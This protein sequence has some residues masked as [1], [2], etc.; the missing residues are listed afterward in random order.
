MKVLMPK[1]YACLILEINSFFSF[2]FIQF[3]RKNNTATRLCGWHFLKRKLLQFFFN[4]SQMYAKEFK[5]RN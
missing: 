2:N 5:S 3:N 1:Y 4:W